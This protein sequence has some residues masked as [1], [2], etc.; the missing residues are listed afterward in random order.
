MS[1]KRKAKLKVM[2]RSSGISLE[3]VA[4]L[5]LTG[6]MTAATPIKRSVLRMLLPMMSPM[7]MSVLPVMKAEKPIATSG[8]PVPKATMVRPIS[9][10]E[11]LKWEAME[12][13]PEISQL[14]P[15]IKRAKPRISKVICRK[16]S[17]LC[18]F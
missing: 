16:A 10:F 17:I 12:E 1:R 15:L 9:C 8:T 14:A 7:S 4:R 5:I 2:R 13:A 6:R 18:L 3:M 11:T